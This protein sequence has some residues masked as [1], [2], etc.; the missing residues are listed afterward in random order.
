[1]PDADLAKQIGRPYEAVRDKRIQL[2]IE[3]KLPRYVSWKAEELELLKGF[4]DEEVA[5]IT[6]RAVTAVRQKRLTL[7]Q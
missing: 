6:G 1:M 3:Y 7:K 5:K 4:A 2:K